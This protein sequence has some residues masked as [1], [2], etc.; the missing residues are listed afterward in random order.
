MIQNSKMRFIFVSVA[1]LFMAGWKKKDKKSTLVQGAVSTQETMVQSNDSGKNRIIHIA[2]QVKHDVVPTNAEKITYAQAL[3]I[4]HDLNIDKIADYFDC[5]TVM[6][7]SF[8]IETLNRPVSPS[9]KSGIINYRKDIIQKLIANPE[10]KKEVEAI[11]NVAAIQEEEIIQLMSDFFIGITC[12]ELQ[13]LALIKQQHPGL[14]PMYEFCQTSSSMRTVGMALNVISLIFMPVMSISLGVGAYQNAQRGYPSG[15]L[16][17]WSGYFA[18][19][20]G[21]NGYFLYDDC[22]KASK[23]RVKM[24]ALNRLIEVAEK[25]ERLSDT[26]NLHN[27]FKISLVDD[28]KG[29]QL[30]KGLKH[31]RYKKEKNSCFSV[32]SVHT[33]LYKVYNNDKHLAQMFASIAEMDTYNAIATKMLASQETHHAFCFAEFIEANKPFIDATSLWNVLVQYPVVN[34][35]SQNKHIILTGPNAGGKT[36]AIRAVL[37][38]IILAQAYGIAAAER[39]V[40]TQFDSI[41]SYLNI[42]DDLVKGDSLFASEIKRA[43]EILHII[44]SLSP[45]QKLFFAL[46][47]LFTGTGVQGGETCAYEFIKKIA[48]FDNVLS[49]YATHFDLLKDLGRNNSALM[50]YKV[51]APIKNNKG[52]LVYPYTLSA[53][54]SDVSVALD[55][56]REANLFD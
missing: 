48:K 10:L 20:S 2:A 3:N 17:F 13:N 12:P 23:K 29:Q 35:L 54:A 4:D 47:E 52:K 31:S 41:L 5:K 45:D 55:M 49:I 32:P 15:E 50:N 14:Y 33:F 16:A 42:S 37:Q 1:I 28:K 46:D 21:V 39:F 7:K 6:G 43:Q 22:S 24:H 40:L 11:L 38:N 34:S 51:N 27:Q 53:G 9:D 56:A 18:V 26:Y 19:L 44:K 25:I 8:L 36:T 30:L